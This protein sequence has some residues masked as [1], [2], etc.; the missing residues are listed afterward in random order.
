MKS[1]RLTF[2]KM[3]RRGWKTKKLKRALKAKRG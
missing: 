3:Y 1:A 2:G